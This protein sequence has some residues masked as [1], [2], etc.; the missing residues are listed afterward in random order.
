M[1]A[2]ELVALAS[3]AFT[4]PVLSMFG[5]APEWFISRDASRADI[6]GFA[7][8]VALLPAAVSR[9]WAWR[10]GPSGTGRAT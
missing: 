1:M 5:A 4:R 7:L 3:F 2:L 10:A 9:S 6:I 8:V